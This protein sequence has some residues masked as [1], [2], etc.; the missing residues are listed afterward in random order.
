MEEAVA[1]V[2]VVQRGLGRSD[3]EPSAR[4]LFAVAAVVELL[5]LVQTRVALG[6]KDGE[7]VMVAGAQELAQVRAGSDGSACG[8]LG[9]RSFLALV[10]GEPA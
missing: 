9:Y 4:V 3:P 10:V 8:L 2:Q 6:R 1:S 5:R 7:T